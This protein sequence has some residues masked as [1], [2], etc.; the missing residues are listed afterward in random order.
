MIV[1]LVLHML[2]FAF[3]SPVV[4]FNQKTRYTVNELPTSYIHLKYLGSYSVPTFTCPPHIPVGYKVLLY[5]PEGN[6]AC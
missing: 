4:L 2:V 5:K 3:I 1:N 6:N